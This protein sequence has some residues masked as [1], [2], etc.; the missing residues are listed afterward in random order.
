MADGGTREPG[1]AGRNAR[2]LDGSLPGYHALLMERPLRI[3]VAYEPTRLA[4][5]HLRHAYECLVPITRRE[6]RSAAPEPVIPTPA[7]VR[8]KE[9]AR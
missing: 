5:E 6:V 7:H 2:V 3:R 4:A 8:R 9:S 1:V